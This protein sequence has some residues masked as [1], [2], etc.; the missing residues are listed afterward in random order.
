[1]SIR[2][3]VGVE[4]RWDDNGMLTPLAV[5][6]SDGRRYEIHGVTQSERV[7]EPKTGESGTCYTCHIRS[8]V[9]TLARHIYRFGRYWYV[10]P[11]QR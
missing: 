6:W 7:R 11:R 4:V 8:P 10:Y 2:R 9:G 1:M 5:I 3:R